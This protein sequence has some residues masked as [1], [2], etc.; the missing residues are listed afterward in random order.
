MYSFQEPS[1]SEKHRHP[2]RLERK[3]LLTILA[4]SFLAMS[5]SAGLS[6]EMASASSLVTKGETKSYQVLRYPFDKESALKNDWA[7]GGLTANFEIRRNTTGSEYNTGYCGLSGWGAWGKSDGSDGKVSRTQPGRVLTVADCKNEATYRALVGTLYYSPGGPGWS[8]FSKAWFPTESAT[9]KASSSGSDNIWYRSYAHWI[10]SYYHKSGKVGIWEGCDGQPQSFRDWCADN[11]FPNSAGTTT[12]SKIVAA[13]NDETMRAHGGWTFDDFASKCIIVI[14]QD[15]NGYKFQDWF[16]FAGGEPS[17]GALKGTKV[18]ETP[19]LAVSGNGVSKKGAQYC[20]YKTKSDAEQGINV[21]GGPYTTNSSGVWATEET[22]PVGQKYYVKETKASPGCARDTT[23]YT[24][25]AVVANKTVSMT[26]NSAEPVQHDIVTLVVQKQGRS[27]ALSPEGDASL[28]NAQFTVKYFPKQLT[29]AQVKTATAERTWV[30]K[31]DADGKAYLDASHKVS[32]NSFYTDADGK[33]CL[34]IGTVSVVETKAPT[35]YKLGDQTP[36]V[37]HITADTGSNPKEILDEFKSTGVGTVDNTPI[38]GG[39][40]VVKADAGTHSSKAQGSSKLD[41]TYT[42]TNNSS[43][44]VQVHDNTGATKTVNPGGVC[45]TIKAELV[46]G[47]WVASTKFADALPYGTYTI[48]ET[49]A[50]EGYALSSPAW[51]R[52]FSIGHQATGVGSRY[53]SADAKKISLSNATLTN[54]LAWN[55][56][57]PIRGD[58]E[59]IKYDENLN[60]P[61]PQGDAIF[62]DVQFDIYNMS[63]GAVQSPEGN[64]AQ[65][66]KNVRV[67]R[68]TAHWDAQ[69]KVY[70]ATTKGTNQT[71]DGKG[72]WK[73][74][75]DW[76]GA[77]AYGEYKVVE[78]GVDSSQGYLLGVWNGTSKKVWTGLATKTAATDADNSTT[79]APDG[80]PTWIKNDKQVITFGGKANAPHDTVQRGNID[81]V[82]YDETTDQSSPQGDADLAGIDFDIINKSAHPVISP[83]D[84]KT[85]VDPGKVVC[86]ITTY[87][88]EATKTYRA[89]TTKTATNNRGATSGTTKWAIPSGW[90]GALAFGQY[91]VVE[92][93]KDAQNKTVATGYMHGTMIAP[94]T[95]NIWHGNAYKDPQADGKVT[96]A[97]SSASKWIDK[98]GAAVIFGTAASGPGN[99]VQRGELELVKYD[100]TTKTSIPQGDADLSNIDFD[101]I[102]KSAHP[103][104]SPEDGKTLIDPGKVVCRITTYYDETTKTYRASTAK[105]GTN[106]RGAT[107]GSGTWDTPASWLGS[108]AYGQYQL[109]EIVGDAAAKSVGTGYKHGVWVSDNQTIWHGNAYK[110]PKANN[111]D[112]FAPDSTSS[113]ISANGTVVSFNGATSG[114]NDTVQRGELE[115]VKYDDT[116]KVSA[117]QGDA[118]LLNI[119]FDIINKSAHPVVSPEDGKTLVEPG[120]VVC[121]ITTYYDET[122]KTYRASTAKKGTN[123]RGVTSGSDT[124]DTPA[125]WRGSLA[126]GQYQAVELANDEAAKTIATGYMHGH[127]FNENQYIWHGNAYKSPG[128]DNQTTFAPD[129]DISWVNADKAVVSFNGQPSGPNNTVQRGDLDI[130]KVDEELARTD[131]DNIIDRQGQ[132]HLDG[133]IFGVYNRSDTVVVSPVDGK[134]IWPAGITDPET[135]QVSNGLVCTIKTDHDGIASTDLSRAAYNGWGADCFAIANGWHGALAYGEYETIEQLPPAGYLLNKTYHGMAVKYTG[136]TPRFTPAIF[137]EYHAQDVAKAYKPN[138]DDT[139]ATWIYKDKALV[140]FG[141][142]KAKDDDGNRDTWVNEQVIRGG[143]KIGKIDRQNQQYKPQGAASLENHLVAIYSRNPHPVKVHEIPAAVSHFD[144]DAAAPSIEIP[145]WDASSTLDLSGEIR[146]LNSNLMAK[147]VSLPPVGTQ[148]KDGVV[149]AYLYTKPVEENGTVKYIAETPDDTLAYGSYRIKE[150][151]VPRNSGYLFDEV[152]AAWYE[153]FGIGDGFVRETGESVLADKAYHTTVSQEDACKSPVDASRSD[154]NEHRYIVDFTNDIK[155]CISNYVLRGD[156]LIHKTVDNKDSN[157]LAYVPF[158]VVSKTTGEAHIIVTDANGYGSTVTT[159]SML[160]MT[161]HT[162]MTNGNDV[163]N[164]EGIPALKKGEDGNFENIKTIVPMSEDGYV[165][166]AEGKTPDFQWVKGSWFYGRTDTLTGYVRKTAQNPDFP[167]TETA[168]VTGGSIPSAFDTAAVDDSCGALPFDDY[169]IFE[170]PVPERDV[171]DLTKEQ[172][173][174]FHAP[175]N[176]EYYMVSDNTFY[177]S[178]ANGEYVFVDPSD[179]VSRTVIGWSNP[180][181]EDIRAKNYPVQRDLDN[182]H[183]PEIATRLADDKGLDLVIPTE[184]TKLID[185]VSYHYLT[186]GQKYKLDGVLHKIVIDENGKKTDGGVL[187]ETKGFEF[188]AENTDGSVQVPFT[189]D[190]SKLGG[191][192]AVCFEY[193]YDATGEVVARHENLEDEDQT[194]I[195]PEVETTLKD[196]DGDK[197]VHSYETVKL[198]DR[199]QYKGL[200]PERPYTAIGTLHLRGDDGSDAG[201]VKDKDGNEITA[202]EVFTPKTSSGYVDV[203]FTFEAV[204]IGGKEVVAF[205]DLYSEDKKFLTHADINDDLQTVYFPEIATTALDGVTNL[206]IGNASTTQQIKDIVVYKNLVKGKTYR[207][208]GKLMDKSTGKEA[209]TDDG[210]EQLTGTL[211]FTAGQD[212]T[213]AERKLGDVVLVDGSVEVPFNVKGE[214]IIGK[215]VVAFEYLYN[216]TD[217]G[218][219]PEDQIGDVL[220]DEGAHEVEISKTDTTDT[221]EIPG[222]TL[223]VKNEKGEIAAQWVSKTTPTKIKLDEGNYTLTEL[224]APKGYLVAETIPFTVGPDGLVGSEKVW[225][226][227]APDPDAGK[228]PSDGPAAKHEDIDD[229]AQTVVYPKLETVASV[230]NIVKSALAD[231]PLTLIDY[232]K[233]ENLIPGRDYI[234]RG[235]LMDKETGKPVEIDGKQITAEQAFKAEEANGTVEVKFDF[236]ATALAGKDVVVFERGYLIK[237]EAGDTGDGNVPEGEIEIGR[238]EDINDESQTVEFPK[239]YTTAAI[240]GEKAA[241]KTNNIVISDEV[242][243]ENLIPG[244]TYVMRATAMD[245]QSEQPVEVDGKQV[246]AEQ[247]FTPEQPDGS[248]KVDTAFDAI[249]AFGANDSHEVV[250]FEGAYQVAAETVDG[251]TQKDVLI[252]KHADIND[253]DQ[254]VRLDEGN[255][256]AEAQSNPAETPASAQPTAVSVAQEVSKSGDGFP[257]IPV[258]AM[259]VLSGAITLIA[260]RRRSIGWHF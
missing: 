116:L 135:G 138:S 143:V 170:L 204:D 137:D 145:A 159:N 23:I 236:D 152:S 29:A 126:Y 44:K 227:D 112:T 251:K 194:I 160:P 109:V 190:A 72:T 83:E 85:V 161:A 79:F 82:K 154:A 169:L 214:D 175:S 205:E 124:W 25:P 213:T 77:L 127:W 252:A 52:K 30:I 171:Q 259:F 181:P 91:Q 254:T 106:H 207:I 55:E 249:L 66:A 18:Y 92:L 187:A 219:E 70:R 241:P 199:I 209:T 146:R 238:H 256:A 193:L 95:Q 42:I 35:G 201:P 172:G 78:V 6:P 27:S 232:V 230:N 136:D 182:K 75:S 105:K 73:T 162:Y 129:S 195:F 62:E 81:L 54:D 115:L 64:H 2:F 216:T 131:K 71:R 167:T 239:I 217:D 179:Q 93:A 258:A 158:A 37:V 31:T 5:L 197:E 237:A 111:T 63:D 113:W 33:I 123:H 34:P 110:E 211:T 186:K 196:V 103:V 166:D 114:P 189:F 228:T 51:S 102:N 210:K 97:A 144:G 36:K 248:V 108:L 16:V 151:Y 86:R 68:I 191:E 231:N 206:H 1:A 233:Y 121:R 141:S 202:R 120:K 56:D 192:S 53:T 212:N 20:V 45:M 220:P 100:D 101:V 257:L 240:S 40:E 48:T 173:D 8:S 46:S 156:I 164:T 128:A 235:T 3:S 243:Y 84:G 74:P 41:A 118:N 80:T 177:V 15:K 148:T 76:S 244:V 67:C 12:A 4:C 14:G 90:H 57:Q 47:K 185:T 246:T 247:E 130:Q 26:T 89:S 11:L 59:V 198:T 224:T 96:F 19:S 242:K 122:T 125:T 165:V 153:D 253:A 60:T 139:Q 17:Y 142:A 94:S 176:K 150:V 223:V 65:I 180:R 98:D 134:W 229:A 38:A 104:V 183:I 13:T 255:L 88:D 49:A 132:A 39:I 250:M 9:G 245:K 28:A 21:V 225:M 163:F 155:Y 215:S 10:L 119:D 168:Y 22:F 58:I 61:E 24:T 203:T 107:T 69:A 117:P 32:G 140:S 50:P 99:T 222:A 7:K 149:A 188:I 178:V 184:K 260:L 200:F 234:M 174:V 218:N 87:Y 221:K 43:A 226:R 133:A 157:T 147:A 208:D